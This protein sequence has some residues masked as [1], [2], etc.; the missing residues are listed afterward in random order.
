MSARA[1][2]NN[3]P[4][5]I[6]RFLLSLLTV[7]LTAYLMVTTLM[8]YFSVSEVSLPN[9]LGLSAEEAILTLE[10]LGFKVKSYSQIVSGV[11]VN[12]ITAQ[13]PEAG[14]VVRQGR[15]ISLGINSSGEIEVP[16]LINSTQ[17]QAKII[18]AALGLELGEV[19]FTFSDIPQ[20]Q[21]ISQVPE[22]TTKVTLNTKVS[23]VISRGP[24]VPTVAIPEVRGLNIDSAIQRLKSLGFT[25][26]DTV[27]SSISS[28]KPQ[29]VTQQSPPAKE[30]VPSS[31]R[32]TLGYSLSS[33]IV[34]AVPNLVGSTLQNAQATLQA[35]GLMLG[36]VSYVTDP[37]KPAG[38]STYAPSRYTVYGAPILVEYNGYEPIPAPASP[39]ASS[40][41]QTPTPQPQPTPN[42]PATS[43]PVPSQ[44]VPSQPVP[45][46]P[47]PET[48]QSPPATPPAP[49][50]P[51]VSSD[52][53][54]DL[55]FVF[56]PKQQGI[57]ALMEQSYNL[58]LEVQDDRGQRELFNRMMSAGEGVNASY[59]VYGEAQVQAFI[60][61]IL[62]QA[63]S[64]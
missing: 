48:V 53:S 33:S 44:P 52:G 16:L 32:I 12:S 41:P 30:S 20:G 8:R 38:I 57:A 55:P 58:R 18:L 14:A 50:T 10:N 46:Q 37:A 4:W 62:Y 26:I 6:T 15:S 23:A 40:P 56:D 22:Q 34:I 63:W 61:D 28:D 49:V 47:A 13:S 31:T 29:T 51:T 11:P 7:I 35:V 5:Q 19:S 3:R 21:V 42:Q 59:K 2:P 54:R 45:S 24:N 25:N 43:Q 27:P 36:P 9:V 1:A 64:Y 17:E 60:N 39:P